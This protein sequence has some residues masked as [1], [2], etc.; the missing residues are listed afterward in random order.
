MSTLSIEERVA[1][2]EAEV[3]KLR[4]KVENPAVTVTPWWEKIA[5]T[6]AHDSVYNEAM[7]L[8]HQYRRSLARRRPRKRKV[9][10]VHS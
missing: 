1:T 9:N 6:F 7:K 4:Q 3:V 2:L 10:H 5:G 8:G